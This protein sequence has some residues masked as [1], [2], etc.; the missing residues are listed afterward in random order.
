MLKDRKLGAMS[1]VPKPV[2]SPVR[3][4]WNT[5]RN[6]APNAGT[7]VIPTT[8]PEQS[9]GLSPGETTVA[10]SDDSRDDEDEALPS[11]EVAMEDRP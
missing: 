2:S 10:A 5:A 4:V 6:T 9:R 1:R 3:A 7:G 11:V 8:L